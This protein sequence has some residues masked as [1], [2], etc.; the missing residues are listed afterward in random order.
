LVRDGEG[1]RPLGGIGLL[2]GTQQDENQPMKDAN[3]HALL[4]TLYDSYATG[5]TSGWGDYLAPDV[6]CI[7]TDQAE[8]WQGRDAILSAA[9]AQLA[10][11]NEAGMR[12]TPG[13]DPLITDRDSYI[14]VAD[15][16]SLN[17]PDGTVIA[18]RLTLTLSR[19]DETLAIQQMHMSVPAPNEAVVHQT[20]PV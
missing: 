2:S 7:G 5:D 12:V 15:R 19:V 11:M 6:L 13:D 20:L 14:L 4:A 16:P 18:V 9:R 10:E 17:L 3:V 8:W 1:N